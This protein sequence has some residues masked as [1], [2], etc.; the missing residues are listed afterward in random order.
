MQLCGS[1]WYSADM[2]SIR[3]GFGVFFVFFLKGAMGVARAQQDQ[4]EK[5]E[6]EKHEWA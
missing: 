5:R 1:L 4:G 3:E 6:T 2:G